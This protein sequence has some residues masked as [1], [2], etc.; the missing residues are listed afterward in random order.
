MHFTPFLGKGLTLIIYNLISIR[1]SVMGLC[2]YDSLLKFL[3]S[4]PFLNLRV[5]VDV[6]LVTITLR[7]SPTSLLVNWHLSVWELKLYVPNYFLNILF[8]KIEC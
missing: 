4:E 3:F 7:S 2:E 5:L 6:S 8:L 1:V